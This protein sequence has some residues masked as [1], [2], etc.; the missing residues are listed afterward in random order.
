MINKPYIIAT[1]KHLN[2]LE[3]NVKGSYSADYIPT[4]LKNIEDL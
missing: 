1:E 2:N 3:V 4:I